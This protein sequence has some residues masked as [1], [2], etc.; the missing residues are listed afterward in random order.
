LA[1]GLLAFIGVLAGCSSPPATAPSAAGGGNL[2]VATMNVVSGNAQSAP[3]N[4]LLPIPI[5]VQVLQSNGQP[6]PNFVIDFVVTSGGGSVYGGAE[7]TNAQGYADERWTLGPRL[8]PQTLQARAVG[9]TNGTEYAY[10]NFT[11]TGLP[12]N[13]V[14][15]VGNNSTG[16]FIMNANGSG[17]KQ[18]LTT[19]GQDYSPDLS[20][21]HRKIVFF[22][23][24]VVDSTS[25]FLMN[26]DGTNI[27][28]IGPALFFSS[29]PPRWSPNDSLIVF[30][31]Q[32]TGAPGITP[33]PGGNCCVPGVIAI[34]TA[35]NIFSSEFFGEDEAGP[36]AWTANGQD[37]LFWCDDFCFGGSGLFLESTDQQVLG[38]QHAP[39]DLSAFAASPD[40][41]HIAFVGEPEENPAP[42]STLY[43]MNTD[44]TNV[45]PLTTALGLGGKLSYS[46]DGSLIAIDHG[47]INADGTSYQVVKG[48]PCSFA[49]T[50]TTFSA[51]PASAAPAR[52]FR[53]RRH[54]HWFPL[55]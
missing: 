52:V 51:G 18:V 32:I 31:G 55:R 2:T 35:G 5:R 13:N 1:N 48:C 49:P 7:I 46:P 20:P 4:T 44:G 17:L 26:V 23:S 38:S 41:Q 3:V 27:H 9:S 53:V 34:D 10:G 16:I 12:P 37:I 50:P 30:A 11:A 22:S 40:G 15:V 14:L 21:D 45:T 39:W 29:G 42:P 47:F 33:E 25:V 28:K 19:G 6:Y 8:G 54:M 36:A 43:T 24:R